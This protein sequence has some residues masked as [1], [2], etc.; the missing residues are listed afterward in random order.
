M[1][2]QQQPSWMASQATRQV[3]FGDTLFARSS[4][5]T[6]ASLQALTLDDVK[7]FY[8]SH[9]T[10]QSAQIVVVGDLSKR[11]VSKQLAFWKAWKDDAAPLY[12]PQVV[13]AQTEQKI[14]LVDKPGRHKVSFEWFDSAYLMM[15]RG[16]VPR[17]VSQL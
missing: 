2:Q 14:Y 11:D 17:S 8:Q 16:N 6:L 7:A 1:Y 3:V 10:P 13:K 9:Y 12:R 4:D 5:G 15:P